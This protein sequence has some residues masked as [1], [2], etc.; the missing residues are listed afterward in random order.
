MICCPA[1]QRSRLSS[2]LRLMA[3][4]LIILSTVSC[5]RSRRTQ[6][7]LDSVEAIPRSAPDS[8]LAALQAIPKQDITTRKDKA[9]YALLYTQAQDRCGIAVASDSLIKD[10]VRYYRH[11]SDHFRKFQ[12]YYYLGQVYQNTGCRDAAMEA[13]VKAESIRSSTIPHNY[14]RA[15]HFRKSSLYAGAYDYPRAIEESELALTESRLAQDTS[16]IFQAM[17]NIA[18]CGYYISI[19]PFV[20]HVMDSLSYYYDNVS[21]EDKI[22]YQALWAELMLEK[23]PHEQILVHLDSVLVINKEYCGK[24]PW[25]RIARVYV[26]A[27][28]P[29]KA[30][31]AL[32]QIPINDNSALD[33]AVLSEA[34]DSLGQPQQALDTYRKYVHMS[35]SIDM[36]LF[37]QDTRFIEE[38]HANQI[39]RIRAGQW[40][41]VLALLLITFGWIIIAKSKRRRAENARLL[42][43][44]KD[45]QDEYGSLQ[46]ILDRNTHVNDAAIAKLG[47]RLR[48][49]GVFLSEK[50]PESLGQVAEKMETLTEDRKSLIETVGLLFAVYHP[51]FVS[52]L[53]DY[54]LTTSEIG[55]CCMHV[56]GYRTSEIGDV[57]NRSSYYNISSDIRKKLPISNQKL[58]TWLSEKFK[59]K[60]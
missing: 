49:I 25:N 36:E 18:E 55:F 19:D 52:M 41:I 24:L 8:A 1:Y 37:R 54:G 29:I 14:L 34:L 48:A 6:E 38:R 60:G 46:D 12:A 26:H 2:A 7:L 17:M 5:S 45:L 20:N 21:Y 53:L 3:I 10:A 39:R 42:R 15:L 33:F 31:D 16:G 58:A 43:M 13:Y 32:R 27:G 40:L 22:D 28:H 56:L 35:D 44:Y 50:R 4:L 11:S 57:I 9:R 47:E 59:E 30:I 51:A 23:I